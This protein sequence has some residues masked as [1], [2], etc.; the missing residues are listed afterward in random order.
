M[1]QD[2]LDH[3]EWLL[4]VMQLRYLM[5]HRFVCLRVGVSEDSR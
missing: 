4:A 1:R 2:F 5:N 3:P